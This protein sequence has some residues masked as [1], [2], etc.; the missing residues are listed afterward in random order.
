M[1]IYDFGP[2]HLST[3]SHEDPQSGMCFME[4]VAFMNGEAWSDRP[5]C[6]CP[7]IAGY[8]RAINDLMPQEWRDKLQKFVPRLIG[9]VSDEHTQERTEYL[10][11]QAVTVFA[12]I[13]CD[14]A[15]LQEQANLLRAQT[16]LKVAP[17][18]AAG[19]AALEA[20]SADAAAAAAA[21]YA[22][23]E[24]ASADADAAAYADAAADAARTAY[25][26]DCWTEAI[27]A[28][29]GVLQIGPSSTAYTQ[30]HIERGAKLRALL[31]A[32]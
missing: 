32:A 11:M 15:G 21:G 22:A 29:E 5:D 4:M 1:N 19:Y 31:G 9:T 20:A 17:A 16:N 26:A 30:H 3:G 6:A 28:L 23:L 24:A 10:A 2:I 25:Y 13:S 12:P 18:A 8:C 14:K 7:V 27:A